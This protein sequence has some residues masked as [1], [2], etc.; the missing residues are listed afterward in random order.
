MPIDKGIDWKLSYVHTMESYTAMRV[1]EL[2]LIGMTEMTLSNIILSAKNPDIKKY[3]LCY[4]IYIKTYKTK[5]G[6]W[7]QDDT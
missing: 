4:Y 5:L 3:V 6:R 7:S 1:N 2:Q